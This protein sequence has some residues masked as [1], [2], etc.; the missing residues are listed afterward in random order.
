MEFIGIG[1]GIIFAIIPLIAYRKGLKD[2]LSIN[3]KEKL[4]EKPKKTKKS[5][6]SEIEDRVAQGLQNILSYDGENEVK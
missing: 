5:E 3:K 4:E 2:G 6:K 1:I